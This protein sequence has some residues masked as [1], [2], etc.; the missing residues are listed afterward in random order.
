MTYN[1]TMKILYI[2]AA[3]EPNRGS[4]PGVGWNVP[5]HF[6]KEHPDSQV[7]LLTC[8]SKEDKIVSFLETH[9]V[10]NLTPLYYDLPRWMK[11]TAWGRHA[12]MG[13]VLWQWLVRK[14]VKRWDREYGFDIIHH[15]TYNQYRSPSPGFF[16]DKPFVMGPVGGAETVNPIFYRDL[17]DETKKKERFRQAG[18]D[19]RLFRWLNG[20]SDNKKHLLFSS[21]ENEER[22]HAYC[23]NSS[24]SVMPAIGFDEDDFPLPNE[25]REH[26]ADEPHVFEMTYAGRPLDWKGLSFF[27]KA[28]NR[29]FVQ[30][31]IQSYRI[32]LVGIGNDQ[33]QEMVK[34]WVGEN[35][36]THHVELIPFMPRKDLLVLLQT[37]DLSVYPAFRDSGSMSVLEASALAC[38]TICFNAG[39]Q[40][41]FP[42]EVL[43][44]IAVGND[45][46]ETLRR[47]ADKLSWAF[48]NRDSLKQIGKK[49][50]KYV[51]DT[52]TWKKK[53]HAYGR[54]YEK[55]LDV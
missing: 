37:C 24:T 4:E 34:R 32:K 42:D 18:A 38:P 8:P 55:M 43:L 49:A 14:L 6:A 23:G 50:Q 52:L 20:R 47:F 9:P 17:S 7:F 19:F 48:C 41:A 54:L 11:R 36:L 10:A 27:L 45:Y 15:V 22:L 44:K 25:T 30:Q 53:V 12:Q 33:E 51:Y 40:D 39:G 28:A 31:G 35:Q 16:M 26:T 21:K 13:Y 2:S 46:D 5:C 3:C 29:A 1:L